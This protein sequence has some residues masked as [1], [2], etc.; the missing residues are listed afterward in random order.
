LADALAGVNFGSV[1]KRKAPGNK[2]EN[3]G[4][5]KK[6]CLK[7]GPKNEP[8]GGEEHVMDNS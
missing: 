4:E 2:R 8:A 1:S 7:G 5:K 3:L 6:K